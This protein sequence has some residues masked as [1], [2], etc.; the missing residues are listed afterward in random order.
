MSG[1]PGAERREANSRGQTMTEYALIIS[2][3][4]LGLILLYQQAGNISSFL[5]TQVVP[6][7]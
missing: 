1:R 2:S 6:L 3:I 5:I 4:L 7:F